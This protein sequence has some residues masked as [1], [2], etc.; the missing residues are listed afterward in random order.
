MYYNPSTARTYTAEQVWSQS[1]LNTIA[2]SPEILAGA[3]FYVVTETT[4]D[5]PDSLYTSAVSYTIAGYTADQTW[6]KTPIAL[7]D[8]KT[9]AVH[10]ASKAADN[11]ISAGLDGSDF[12]APLL[13][14]VLSLDEAS[15]GAAFR[16]DLDDW[17]AKTTLLQ[18]QIDAIN[19]STTVDQISYIAFPS[20]KITG[21]L[22]ITRSGSNL[23]TA[24]FEDLTGATG[25]DFEIVGSGK[26][27]AYNT[28]D[29][30]FPATTGLWSG[31]PFTIVL[32][33]GGFYAVLNGVTVA[34]GD[35]EHALNWEPVIPPMPLT[36]TT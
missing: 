11:L 2:T 6:A 7:A 24:T 21:K 27:V 12:N 16:P 15:R 5:Y 32:R 14:S 17:A 30:A 26:T 8:A 3:G 9:A 35:S 28:S 18:Q 13:I 33:Y 34:S 20:T 10:A 31:S 1:G 22:K 36:Y 25:G 23:T 29:N 19:A 4:K